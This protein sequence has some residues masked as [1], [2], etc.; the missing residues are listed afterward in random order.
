MPMRFDGLHVC[1]EGSQLIC[2]GGFPRS[3]PYDEHGAA[4]FRGVFGVGG[5]N[6]VQ[7]IDP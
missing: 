2:A 4:L 7:G 6:R 5:I 3:V 1:N